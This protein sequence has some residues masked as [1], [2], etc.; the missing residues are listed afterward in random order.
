MEV[1]KSNGHGHAQ[2][3]KSAA[4]GKTGE[5]EN[6]VIPEGAAA[7]NGKGANGNRRMSAAAIFWSAGHQ[8]SLDGTDVAP[9]ELNRASHLSIQRSVLSTHV[10]DTRTGRPAHGLQCKAYKWD[11]NTSDWTEIGHTVTNA[12]GRI[13]AVHTGVTLS[14][15]TYKMRFATKE[16]FEKHQLSTFLPYIEVVIDVDDPSQHLHVPLLLT[17][18]GYTVYKGC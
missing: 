3:Q 14:R 15:G 6:L 12:Q 1:A 16:Y 10:L 18:F 4:V 9:S 8:A 11:K 17:P 5:K 2:R 7:T 13:P